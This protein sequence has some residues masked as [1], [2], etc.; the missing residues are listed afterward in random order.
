MSRAL[1]YQPPADAGS[2]NDPRLPDAGN[3]NE[4]LKSSGGSWVLDTLTSADVGGL[5]SLATKS[6][7]VNA[8]VDAAAAIAKSK[9]ASLA[10]VN[11]D[12]DAAAAI[13]ASK[14][15][16][17]IGP[18]SYTAN[19]DL[20]PIG[21]A[22]GGTLGAALIP[23]FYPI[24][25][26]VNRI[27]IAALAARV[28][29]LESSSSIGA[30][31]YSYTVPS[32]AHISATRVAQLNASLAGTSAAR[33]VGDVTT[34]AAGSG[35]AP[36]TLDF[37]TTRY[38]MG[39]MVSSVTTLALSSVNHGATLLNVGLMRFSGSGNGAARSSVTDWPSS[40]DE[41]AIAAWAG[42]RVPYIGM[43]TATGK[44]LF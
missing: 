41:T 29:A 1:V 17:A 35:A 37:S 19:A 4:Y 16:T 25:L 15:V 31:I 28:T 22:S 32:S 43:M 18:D 10:I 5:G 13:A 30:A 38:L 9:L 42:A 6:T 24:V 14:L 40:F 33:P 26:P 36:V 12:V 34:G 3:S 8:D 21:A 7:I 2:S 27:T 44:N 23:F 20:V 11:A 39:V